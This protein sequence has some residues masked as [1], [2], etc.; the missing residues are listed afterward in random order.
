VRV[1]GEEP[2]P[3]L[4]RVHHQLRADGVRHS[5]N[6]P[7]RTGL[8]TRGYLPHVKRQGAG[9]FVTYRLA[10]SLP[11]GVL[12]KLEAERA[13]KLRALKGEKDQGWFPE[14]EKAIIERN[15]RREIERQLD[16]CHG[17]CHLRNPQIGSLIAA[18][19]KYF[20]GQRYLLYEWVVMPNHV[21]LIVQPMSNFLLS[22]ILKTW[23]QYTSLRAKAILGLGD[24]PFWQPESYDHWIRNVEEH[25]HIARYIRNNPV[26]AHL[27]TLAE[28]WPWSSGAAAQGE[29]PAQ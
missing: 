8:H 25:D 3:G 24:G 11:K 22:N 4:E 26:K 5:V 7:L 2:N 21:H 23:K 17:A 6:N 19:L 14:E 18:N 10:D 20:N 27:C 1:E 29:L 15:F 13:Q 28:N 12:L 16:L 9:Y